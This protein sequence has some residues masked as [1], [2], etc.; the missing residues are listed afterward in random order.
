MEYI[1]PYFGAKD[2]KLRIVPEGSK[3][4][5]GTR[6]YDSPFEEMKQLFKPHFL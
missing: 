2:K 5:V 3:M 1:A 4:P 6:M